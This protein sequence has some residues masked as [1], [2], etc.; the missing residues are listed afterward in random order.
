MTHKDSVP[1]MLP[2]QGT[3]RV[4][5]A[6]RTRCR[7][8]AD[9]AHQGSSEMWSVDT[10]GELPMMQEKNAKCLRCGASIQEVKKKAKRLNLNFSL[11]GILDAS[12]L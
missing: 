6:E 3:V 5:S 2:L 11:F 1:R 12:G 8:S 10:R 7:T 4:G 9:F